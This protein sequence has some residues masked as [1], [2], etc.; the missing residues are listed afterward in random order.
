MKRNKLISVIALAV[1][2]GACGQKE[3]AESYITAAKSHLS[4]NNINATKIELKNAIKLEPQNAEARFLLGQ[5]YL[6]E[7]S[8]VDAVK[9]LE[10]AKKLKHNSSK[11]PAL[12][13]RAYFISRDEQPLADLQSSLLEKDNE[14][15]AEVTAYL[16]LLQLTSGDEAGK[17]TVALLNESARNQYFSGL[18]TAYLTFS[19]GDAKAAASQ[20]GSL[21]KQRPDNPEAVLLAGQV[22]NQLEEFKQAASY[23]KKYLQLQPEQKYV[24]LFLAEALVKDENYEEGESYVDSILKSLPEQ[25]VANYLKAL[26]KFTNKDYDA[27]LSFSDVALRGNYNT[28]YLQLI[29][30]S[31]AFYLNNF[32]RAHHHLNTVYPYLIPEHPARKMFAVSQLK[33]GQLESLSENLEDF[34]VNNETDA[35]FLSSLSFNLYNLGATKEAKNI[36]SKLTDKENSSVKQD[37]NSGIL[38]MLIND[39]SAVQSIESALSKDSDIENIDFVLALM[40]LQK[41]D[42]EQALVHVDK[43]IANNQDKAQGYNFKAKIFLAQNKL[44]E[45]AKALQKSLKVNEKEFYALKNLSTIAIKNGD[46]EEAKEIAAKLL[47]FYP[48]DIRALRHNF[49]VNQDDESKDK[50]KK[51][52]LANQSNDDHILL[53]G[54]ILYLSQKHNEAVPVFEALSGNLDTPK[55]AWILKVSNYQR[56]RNVNGMKRTAQAWADANGYHEEPVLMLAELALRERRADD[57]LKILNKGLS[58]LLADNARIQL[59]KLQLLLDTGNSS[60]AGKFYDEIKATITDEKVNEGIEG[61]LLLLNKDFQQAVPKL[62]NFYKE[63]PSSR[64]AVFYAAALK[65]NRDLAG[66]SI[67]LERHISKFEHDLRARNALAD[68]YLGLDTDK[69]ITQ[70]REIIKLQPNS[71]IALNNLA[72]L[73][74]EKGQL[75][76]AISYSQLAYER[77][78]QVASVVDTYALILLKM[79]KKREALA[80]SKEAFDLSQGKDLDVSLNYIE[81]LLANS[82]KNEAK[83]LLAKLEPKNNRQK[84]RMI[85]LMNKI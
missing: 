80:K 85:E 2:L 67:H 77:A 68:V 11:L 59:A 60:D 74:M 44:L 17:E 70:Y 31:S 29:A 76:E 28:P 34:E 71:I 62:A 5:L 8:G 79:D 63:F 18:S 3:T 36:A 14:I 73:T 37:L 19:N 72:W 27:A 52:Y 26:I 32:E 55:K 75:E 9:E 16:A 20:L 64:S 46:L 47:S 23:F 42:Y 33:L 30:G 21:L 49:L 84:T 24:T 43:W 6:S 57:A 48:D 58:G 81:I 69:A 40:S 53:Y 39:P 41:E 25:P 12:L 78:P 66:A 65:G 4:E 7:G 54:E 83:G 61:R 13:A 38:K 45:A 35:A 1:A 50:I 22:Y 15:F 51:A 10:R 82:R 56:I